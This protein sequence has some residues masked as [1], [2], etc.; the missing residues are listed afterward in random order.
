MQKHAYE[1]LFRRTALCIDSYEDEVP[2]GRIYHPCKPEGIPFRG[3]TRFLLEM[4]EILDS[5]QCPQSFTAARRFGS[6]VVESIGKTAGS[7]GKRGKL[8]TFEIRILFR[9]NASWQGSMLWIEEGRTHSFRSVL[10]LIL[11]MDSALQGYQTE[12]EECPA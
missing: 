8:A 9:Q 5:I 4:E 7:A 6:H 12:E 11:L 1:D 2:T 3:T 10:E